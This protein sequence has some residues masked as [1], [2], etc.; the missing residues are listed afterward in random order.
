MGTYFIQSVPCHPFTARIKNRAWR[1]I[2]SKHGQPHIELYDF[3]TSYKFTTHTLDTRLDDISK[4]LLTLDMLPLNKQIKNLLNVIDD[5]VGDY[6]DAE[7][8]HDDQLFQTIRDV[9]IDLYPQH[10]SL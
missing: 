5:V 7:D 8:P 4:I 10:S 9:F 2:S 6:E 1:S 3:G